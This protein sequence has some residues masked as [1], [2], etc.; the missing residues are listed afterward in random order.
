M[1]KW[2]SLTEKWVKL[3]REA[4]AAANVIQVQALLWGLGLGILKLLKLSF[5][6]QKIYGI[7][8]FCPDESLPGDDSKLEVGGPQGF[9]RG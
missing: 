8:S 7:D 9:Q 6:T 3:N 5:F 1:V 2:K 4:I